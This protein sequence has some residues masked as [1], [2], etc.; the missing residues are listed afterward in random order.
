MLL[1]VMC[2]NNL[3]IPAEIVTHRGKDVVELSCSFEGT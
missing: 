2:L 3:C 1:V